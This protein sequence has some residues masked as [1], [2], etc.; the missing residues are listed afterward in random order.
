MCE[1]RHIT[2]IVRALKRHSLRFHRS[3]EVKL[4]CT[5]CVTMEGNAATV[6]LDDMAKRRREDERMTF[7]AR[8]A[9]GQR[10]GTFMGGEGGRGLKVTRMKKDVNQDMKR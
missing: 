6:L 7:R 10:R 9:R 8:A 5:V 3:Q 4:T 2:L 1:T